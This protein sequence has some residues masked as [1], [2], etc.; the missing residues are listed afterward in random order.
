MHL[1]EP[2]ARRSSSRT[3]VSVFDFA[4]VL[5]AALVL[6]GGCIFMLDM[7]SAQSS[8]HESSSLKLLSETSVWLPALAKT[9]G[10]YALLFIAS[11]VNSG[12][13]VLL[14]QGLRSMDMKLSRFTIR[15]LKLPGKIG[16]IR[17]KRA[18]KESVR[19]SKRREATS[20]RESSPFLLSPIFR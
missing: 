13:I 3:S 4:F 17:G 15:D 11:I 20:V 19:A 14:V 10:K 2:P 5:M 16:N 8:G 7:A 12:L 6:V 9:A 18:H 1:A